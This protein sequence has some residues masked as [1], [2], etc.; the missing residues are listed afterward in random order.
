MVRQPDSTDT[1]DVPQQASY[2]ETRIIRL[3]R[4]N[5]DVLL[6]WICA[7]GTA[8]SRVSRLAKQAKGYPPGIPRSPTVIVYSYHLLEVTCS[9]QAFPLSDQ[10]RRYRRWPFKTVDQ[11]LSYYS[12]AAWRCSTESRET[13][14]V[15]ARNAH[16]EVRLR[17]I[18]LGCLFAALIVFAVQIHRLG[19]LLLGSGLHFGK[20]G[21]VLVNLQHRLIVLL[22]QRPP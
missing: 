5:C 3:A 16:L 6:R 17:C 9:L 14:I 18:V 20:D 8:E 19:C 2:K 11:P 7:C 22:L 10:W 13:S 12:I 1:R 4:I 15:W 21:L